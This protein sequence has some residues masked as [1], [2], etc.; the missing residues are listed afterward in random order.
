M[1]VLRWI[2]DRSLRI[3]GAPHVLY[4]KVEVGGVCSMSGT[5][6]RTDG[7]QARS[8]TS[9]SSAWQTEEMLSGK[10]RRHDTLHISTLPSFVFHVRYTFKK[11]NPLTLVVIGLY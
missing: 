2:G 6:R 3:A 8:S 5:M 10:R 7:A 9:R 4:S 1:S 11:S